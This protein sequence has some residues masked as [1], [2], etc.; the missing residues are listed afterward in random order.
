[1]QCHELSFLSFFCFLKCRSS[2]VKTHFLPECF[3]LIHKPEKSACLCS[4]KALPL[5]KKCWTDWLCLAVSLFEGFCEF[6]HCLLERVP[7]SPVQQKMPVNH[8]RVKE[9]DPNSFSPF[10]LSNTSLCLQPWRTSNSI[11]ACRPHPSCLYQ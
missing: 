10:P 2:A 11:L 1:M 8:L 3:Y 4:S 9:E 7:S 6:L 5:L